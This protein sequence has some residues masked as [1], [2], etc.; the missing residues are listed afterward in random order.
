MRPIIG[1]GA[2][3][4]QP[5][6][7]GIGAL[8]LMDALQPVGVVDLKLDPYGVLPILGAMAYLEPLATV[9]VLE[10]GGLLNLATAISPA[11]R[12]TG[13]TAMEV[14][15]K[16]AS[17]RTVGRTVQSGSLTTIPIPAGQKAQVT[18]KLSRGL[19]LNGRSR[20]NLTVEGSA[21]G[22]I[23]DGRGRPLLVPKDL[24]RRAAAL[25]RWYAGV[26]GAAMVQVA[27]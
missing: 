17:G 8:L 26:A 12:P 14:A 10:N 24:D 21:A 7:P 2:I 15:V 1:A 3:L 23:C 20:L 18:I 9:Q 5:I 22:L 6:N 13:G 11:G 4:A 19:T 25:P 27:E 16:Y